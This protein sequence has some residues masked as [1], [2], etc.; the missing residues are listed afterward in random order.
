MGKGF[1]P[2]KS[3]IIETILFSSQKSANAVAKILTAT[4]G[5]E[6][7]G[8]NGINIMDN[9]GEEETEEYYPIVYENILENITLITAIEM[10]KTEYCRQYESC[11][12]KISFEEEIEMV[13]NGNS[14]YMMDESYV[15]LSS[16]KPGLF[17]SKSITTGTSPRRL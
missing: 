12:R 9:F 4:K 11:P 16:F 7:D 2:V 13:L 6:Y 14:F 5:I 3:E 8:C 15:L 1:A 10:E 17:H